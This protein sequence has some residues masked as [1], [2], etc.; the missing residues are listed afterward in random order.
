MDVILS[1]IYALQKTNVEIITRVES[2]QEVVTYH[3]WIEYDK[4]GFMKLNEDV[5]KRK[6]TPGKKFGFGVTLFLIFPFS[7]SSIIA[8]HKPALKFK[9]D[10]WDVFNDKPNWSAKNWSDLKRLNSLVLGIVE[11]FELLDKSNKKVA[12]E[13]QKYLHNLE[14]IQQSL[15]VVESASL[16]QHSRKAEL[17]AQSNKINMQI[18]ELLG[19]GVGIG[20]KLFLDSTILKPAHKAK[21][22]EWYGSGWQLLYKASIDGWSSSKFHA[23]CDAKGKTITVVSHSDGAFLVGGFTS[24]NWSSTGRY[25]NDR[26]ASIFSLVNPKDLPPTKFGTRGQN[27]VLCHPNFGPTFGVENM[28]RGHD[29]RVSNSPNSPGACS[30]SSFPS[31]YGDTTDHGDG[32]FDNGSPW[33]ANEIEVYYIPS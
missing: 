31:T 19:S 6:G 12:S 7:V 3:C 20:P 22:V 17:Q 15:G 14:E 8:E 29:L 4:N 18:K 13:L 16:S 10:I 2:V 24:T 5:E 25:Q 11:K 1:K 28:Y 23:K 33:S 27:A 26:D 30:P 21:L 32:W 9:T